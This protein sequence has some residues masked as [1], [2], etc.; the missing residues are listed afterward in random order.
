[1]QNNNEGQPSRVNRRFNRLKS[2]KELSLNLHLDEITN[3]KKRTEEN[4]IFF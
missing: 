4:L 3:F 2:H 1:M